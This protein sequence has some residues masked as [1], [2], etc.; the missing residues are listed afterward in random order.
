MMW[1]QEVKARVGEDTIFTYAL[2]RPPSAAPSVSV[3]LSGGVVA[4][5]AMSAMWTAPTVSAVSASDRTVLTLDGAVANARGLAADYGDAWLVSDETAP[6]RVKVLR[7]LGGPARAI[8]AEPLPVEHS[9]AGTLEPAWYRVT[10]PALTVTATA[11]RDA[12]LSVTWTEDSGTDGPAFASRAEMSLHVVRE[13]FATGVTSAEVLRVDSGLA[14]QYAHRDVDW[15]AAIGA[16]LDEVVMRLRQDLAEG[17]RWEDDVLRAHRAPLATCHA[18]LAAAIIHDP[19]DP[20]AADRHRERVWGV[21]GSR[22]LW[23]AAL[24]RILLDVDGNGLPDEGAQE[25]VV[26]PRVG[27][28]GSFT[29]GPADDPL[30]RRNS[31]RSF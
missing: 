5:G 3:T 14:S 25:Q 31:R 4:V 10:L 21:D 1:G 11:Q 16:A 2:P 20:A 13:P 17:G 19:Y 8:L 26:G 28:L 29:A 22:G 24:R 30:W 7:F 27:S 23:H 15:R 9:G 18:H 12:L 6:V